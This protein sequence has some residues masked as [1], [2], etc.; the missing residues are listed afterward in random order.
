MSRQMNRRPSAPMR[1]GP[2]EDTL[3]TLMCAE[4]RE[5]P[6]LSLTLEQACRLWGAEPLVCDAALQ[7]LVAE[8]V[9]R[10]THK[11]AYVWIG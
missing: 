6:G 10:R 2:S 9:L 7:R 5:M 1:L 8:R 4:F 3:V 11:G